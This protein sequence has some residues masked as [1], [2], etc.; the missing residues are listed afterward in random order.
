MKKGRQLTA[1]SIGYSSSFFQDSDVIIGLE[2]TEDDDEM[3]RVL[4]IVESRNCGK[5]EV[6]LIWNWEEGQFVEMTGA[7]AEASTYQGDPGG[8]LD[9]D[10]MD[11]LA[12]G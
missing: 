8:G 3:T 1:D 9:G 7:F 4:K 11:A 12:R 10:Y 5:V 2:R 6:D